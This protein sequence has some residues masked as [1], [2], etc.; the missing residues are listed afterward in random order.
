MDKIEINK[1]NIL[2]VE[3]IDDIG[4]FR[5][6]L[7]S[8]GITDVQIIETGS[9]SSFKSIIMLISKS[10]NL[11]IVRKLGFIRDA[12]TNPYDSYRSIYFA[13]QRNGLPF[14]INPQEFNITTTPSVGIFIMPDHD[15]NGEL[16]DIL[17]RSIEG[18]PIENCINNYFYCIDPDVTFCSKAKVLAYL[19]SFGK[20][21]RDY[22]YNIATAARKGY[23]DFDHA[24]FNE[25]RTF[26]SHYSDE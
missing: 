23:W 26:L 2:V 18:E 9:D 14:P 19:A 1:E 10:S 17:L 5:S 24:V 12:D 3:G 22:V 20:R 4:F 13:L 6:F 7:G 16:E 21:K 25:V 11:H 15:S 8:I